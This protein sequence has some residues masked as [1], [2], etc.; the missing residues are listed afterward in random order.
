MRITAHTPACV[1]AYLLAPTAMFVPMVSR[2]T[3]IA[4]TLV[5]LAAGAGHADAQTLG[6]QVVQLATKK[7]LG[8]ASVALVNDSAQVVAS[9]AASPD[10][11]FFLDAPAPGGYRVVLFVSGASFVSPALQLD[12]GKTVERQ[13]SVPDVPETFTATLFA[14]DVT[15]PATM[16]PNSPRPAYPAGP[17]SKG[18]RALV[19]TMF[20]VSET[21]LPDMTTFRVL[22]TSDADFV[23][24]VRDAL[25]RTRFVPADKDG[26][27]VAQVV[28]FTYDFALDGDP[29]RGDLQIRPKGAPPPRP[30]SKGMA[31]PRY[32][33]TAEEFASTDV[34]TLTLPEALHKLRPALFPEAATTT[35]P[36]DGPIYV[37][38]VLVDGMSY[39]RHIPARNAIEVRFLKREEAA[40][41]Y[42]MQYP[43]VVLVKLRPD[44]P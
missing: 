12:S 2:H 13:F 30:D 1:F 20:V 41:Q 31:R 34:E 7:P 35:K 38:G 25:H 37:N 11:E 39:L 6:G 24:A 17:A 44:A 28:Q 40:L 8:G 21:G 43:Y 19:S 27:P 3:R 32:V 16:L 23:L 42:G 10:G 5:A 4:L 18:E 9:T 15:T 36:D 26:N 29:L 22:S 33:I 14:R